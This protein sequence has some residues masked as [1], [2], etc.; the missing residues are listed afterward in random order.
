VEKRPSPAAQ[1]Y[2]LRGASAKFGLHV[3]YMKFNPQNEE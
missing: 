3:G 1:H 2:L